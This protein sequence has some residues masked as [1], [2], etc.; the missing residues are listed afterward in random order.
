MHF[1][2]PSRF[3]RLL[4]KVFGACV[5]VGLGL[6]DNCLLQ[7]RGRRSGRLY[8]TPVNVLSHGGKRYL[9]A[10]RGYTQ[11]VRNAIASGEVVLKKGTQREVCQVCVVRDEDKPPILKL[12]LDRHRLTVQ[13]FF[14][15]RAGSPSH[16][17]QPI[18]QR[19]PVF[20]LVPKDDTRAVGP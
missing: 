9:V 11:W 14:P 18:A 6:R 19:Y 10:G 15:V 12:C 1:D 17:F 8:S 3:E 2:P 20:E 7:V 5:A 4:V 13:R 16:A